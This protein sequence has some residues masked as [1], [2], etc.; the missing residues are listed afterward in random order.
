MNPVKAVIVDD[1][2]Y[3]CERLKKLLYPYEQIQ[4]EA[5]FT[6]SFQ[7]VDFIN[8]QKPELLFLDIE[9]ENNNTAFDLL[10]QID[11]THYRPTIILVTAHSQYT[12]K[13]IKHEVFDYIMKPV[14]VDE[15]EDTIDRYLKRISLKSDQNL[16]ELTMLSEREKGVLMYVMEGKS[17]REIADLLF[18]SINT[19]H[20]HRRNILKKTGSRS[21]LDIFKLRTPQNE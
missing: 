5:I 18:I 15:L 1:E 11:E 16:D 20:T 19:V 17:S 6:N 12:I 4:V 2:R 7:A 9:L 3:S 8:R 14:D 21:F 13:A 10:N